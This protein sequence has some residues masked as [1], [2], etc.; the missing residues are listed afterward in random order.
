MARWLANQPVVT[1]PLALLS[2]LRAPPAS[3]SPV[4]SAPVFPE[5][6]GVVPWRASSC[7]AP[8]PRGA[9]PR[10]ERKISLCAVTFRYLTMHAGCK[11]NL[12]KEP[13]PLVFVSGLLGKL[14]LWLRLPSSSPPLLPLAPL[15]QCEV[16]LKQVYYRPPGHPVRLV[17]GA[18]TRC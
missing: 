15:P 16:G 2:S 5:F 18:M 1:C 14:W 4:R 3:Q 9:P 17:D 11:P 13:A 12:R 7:R 10:T 8:L 6:E